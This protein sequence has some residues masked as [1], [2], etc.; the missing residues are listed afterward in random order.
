MD[1]RYAI[2]VAKTRLREAYECADV[3]GVLS[4]FADVFT[5]L[6]ESHPTLSHVDARTVLRAR[7]EKLFRENQV[8]F[9]PIVI[10]IDIAGA[11]AVEH[12][13]HVMK[14]YPKAGGPAESKR[15]RYVEVWHRG[16]DSNWRIV[17]FIDNSDL[18]P[19]LIA[20]TLEALAAIRA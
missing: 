8:E 4:V 11:I 12:G 5:D 1:D 14:L 16:P 6:S 9:A 20:D 3:E 13:W 19:V 2:N 10:D 18:P 15:T 17:L 7:L